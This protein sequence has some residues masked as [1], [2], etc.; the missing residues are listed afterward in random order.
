MS[1]VGFYCVFC[2]LSGRS[3]GYRKICSS[4]TYLLECFGLEIVF[5]I[6]AIFMLVYEV[7]VLDSRLEFQ[8]GL[9]GLLPI[10]NHNLCTVFFFN[11]KR[12]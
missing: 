1:H 5:N 12:V 6:A 3:V 8:M 2:F 9:I 10:L 7:A 11:L 4:L